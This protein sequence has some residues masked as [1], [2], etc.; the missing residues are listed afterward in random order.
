MAARAVVTYFVTGSAM[1][2]ELRELLHV[3]HEAK[4][5]AVE[6][7]RKGQEDR[8]TRRRTMT[9]MLKDLPGDGARQRSRDGSGR[10]SDRNEQGVF[11]NK[12]LVSRNAKPG[13][14]RTI[15]LTA[16]SVALN[17]QLPRSR[18]G[19][20]RCHGRAAWQ[21]DRLQGGRPPRSERQFPMKNPYMARLVGPPRA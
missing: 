19:R 10:G 11:N 16:A 1:S 7:W 4:E 21:A 14:S 15:G 9:I 8:A 3:L 2:L 6:G 12:S 20:C 13:S 18:V 17:L 5:A